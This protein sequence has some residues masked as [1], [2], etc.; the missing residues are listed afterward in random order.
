MKELKLEDPSRLMNYR[1]LAFTA[2]CFGAGIA[3]G[4][5][6]QGS[7]LFPFGGL[8]FCFAAMALL[9]RYKRAAFALIALLA[10]VLRITAAYPALPPEGEYRLSGVIYEVPRYE[11]GTWDILLSDADVNGSRLGGRVSLKF[12][13]E[14]GSLSFSA[15]E[16]ITVTAN[17]SLPKDA[18]NEGEPDTRHYLLSKSI[19]VTAASDR[20]IASAPAKPDLHGAILRAQI[21]VCKNI[22]KLY[23][24]NSELV[25][26]ILLGFDDSMDE[27]MLS[28]FRDT[29][30]SHILSVSGL[31]VGFFAAVLSFIL[32]SAGAKIRFAVIGIFLLLYCAITAFPE[33]LVRA[34]VMT[35][36]MLFSGV[37]GRRNDPPTSLAAAFMLLLIINPFQLYSVGFQL[38]FGAVA[39]LLLLYKPLCGLFKGLFVP[40]RESFAVSVSATMGTLPFTLI[41]F[42]RLPVYSVIANVFAVP[43]SSLALIPAL[44]AVIVC[45][46]SPAL[47]APIAAFSDLMLELM[48][49]TVRIVSKMPFGVL[50]LASP[51]FI[52]CA[53]FTVLMLL[54]SPFALIK[55]AVKKTGTALIALLCVMIALVPAFTRPECSIAVLDREGCSPITMRV[56]NRNYILDTGGTRGSYALSR[57]LDHR[58]ITVIDG[59]VVTTISDAKAVGELSKQYEIRDVYLFSDREDILSILGT[60][61]VK[62]HMVGR[63]EPYA[64]NKELSLYYDN[65]LIVQY[66]DFVFCIGNA[67]EN[68][69][70]RVVTGER[71]P[72]ALSGAVI[73]AGG[74]SVTNSKALGTNVFCTSEQ[75]EIVIDISNG[76]MSVSAAALLL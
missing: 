32:K 38:S 21:A 13:D 50:K 36:L 57:L 9:I 54:I 24:R 56:S 68:A 76:K 67:R 5:E 74:S 27:Q 51:S 73:F 31:H 4:K 19:Y 22:E 39:G 8:I 40:L 71:E 43:L 64:V 52:L 41:I 53:V 58:G 37:A 62:V 16:S 12:R 30:L 46:V 28:D 33:S 11:Y 59:A 17:I 66:G 6:F 20:L 42:N 14:T 25:K 65:G 7:G 60:S 34:A 1:P 70:V 2:L 45:F 23:P 72:E 55:P 69:A 15:G 35:A 49:F 18:S 3:L 63:K 26:G 61:S 10:G 44:A 29:G 47:A 48:L 75:G